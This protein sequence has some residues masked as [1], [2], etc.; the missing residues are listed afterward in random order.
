MLIHIITNFTDSTK[1]SEIKATSASL[2]ATLALASGGTVII[3]PALMEV[4]III[5]KSASSAISD[6]EK[7]VKGEGVNIIPVK[8]SYNLETYYKDYL[9]AL[10]L[11]VPLDVKLKRVEAII[12]SNTYLTGSSLFAGVKVSCNFRNTVYELDGFYYD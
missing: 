6:Y 3:D 10:L 5:L 4:V 8:C 11:V 2:C 1:L 7:L 9:Q 12:K